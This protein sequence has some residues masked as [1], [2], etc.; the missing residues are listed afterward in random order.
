MKTAAD[1]ALWLVR[2]TGSIQIV[3]GVVIWFGIADAFITI[4]IVSGIIL[5][6]SLWILAFVAARGGENL[7]L[8]VLAIFWGLITVILGLKHDAL[9]PGQS[10]WI[11]Q[12]IH[13]LVGMVAI[14]LALWL[15]SLITQ[16]MKLEAKS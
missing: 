13:L 6:L 9:F 2:I 8:V 3:L 15:S 4:H 12:V 11:I 5:V 1:V 16:S 7:G 14:G 10:H